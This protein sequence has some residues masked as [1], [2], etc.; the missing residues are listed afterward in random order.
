MRNDSK[1]HLVPEGTLV[2]HAGWNAAVNGTAR[3]VHADGPGL[4]WLAPQCNGP[5]EVVL[6][7]SGGN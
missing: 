5:C 4:M 6:D 7:Y 1:A 3:Q 2:D